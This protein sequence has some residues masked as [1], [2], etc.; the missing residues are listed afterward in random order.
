M[1]RD[2]EAA[3]RDWQKEVALARRKSG[4]DARSAGP[5][6]AARAA[7]LAASGGVFAIAAGRLFLEAYLFQREQLRRL[8]LIR[9]SLT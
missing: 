8:E 4:P 1:R 6:S 7:A 3:L 5:G 2:R 9:P